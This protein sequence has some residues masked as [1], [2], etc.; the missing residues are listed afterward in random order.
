MYIYDYIPNIC[1]YVHICTHTHTHTYLPANIHLY[2]HTYTHIHT[3][4]IVTG[5]YDHLPFPASFCCS[6]DQ[7]VI[8]WKWFMGGTLYLPDPKDR[9]TIVAT[10]TTLQAAHAMDT[11]GASENRFTLYLPSQANLEMRD[12]ERAYKFN[13]DG[14]MTDALYDWLMPYYAEP[15]NWYLKTEANKDAKY[16]KVTKYCDYSRYKYI[17][18]L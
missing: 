14:T 2:I 3:Y 17:P 10:P 6:N 4:T 12:M 7:G 8:P 11:P 18:E 16:W 15:Y 9:D 5:H 1:V 13:A